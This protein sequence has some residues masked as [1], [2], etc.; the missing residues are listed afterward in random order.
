[1]ACCNKRRVAQRLKEAQQR[2]AEANQIVLFR[3][4]RDKN[5]PSLSDQLLLDYH[6]KTHMLYA[7]AV[8]RCPL[9]KPLVNSIVDLHDNFVK[10]MLARRMKHNTPLKKV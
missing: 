9:N 10:E 1:M 6:R 2:V 5:P 8:S 3:S 4:L 7:G